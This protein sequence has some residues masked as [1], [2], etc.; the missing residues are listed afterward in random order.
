M[1]VSRSNR[2]TVQI[3]IDGPVASGKT[4]VGMALARRLG[5]AF[6]DTGLMY[7]AVAWAAL[8]RGVPADD[9]PAVAALARCLDMKPLDDASGR[10]LADG[11]DV[12]DFLRLPKVEDVVPGVAAMPAV[13]VALIAR[14]RE[15]AAQAPVVMVGRDIGSVVLPDAPVKLFLTATVRTRAQRRHDERIRKGEASRLEDVARGIER[16]DRLDARQSLPAKD[17]AIV[18]TDCMTIEEVVALAMKLWKGRR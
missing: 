13:R 8:A 16:R 9:E 3:A 7:R 10:L 12:T 5:C 18:E 15:I 11:E 14:Q 1:G 17:A 4:V 2:M 6:L